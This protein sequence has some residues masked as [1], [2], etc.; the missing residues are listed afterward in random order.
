MIPKVDVTIANGNIGGSQNTSD[1]VC[2]YV[3]T[4]AGTGTIALLQPVKVVSLADAE[5]Q[6]LTVIAEPEAQQF[7]SDFYDDAPMGSVLYL[8]LAPNTASLVN[9]CDKTNASG[10][11]KLIDFA[12][13]NAG[14][15]IRVLGISRTPAGG[16]V[17]A[18]DEF[19][20]S[21]AILAGTN[22]KALVTNYFSLH[23]PFRII[24]A[25]RVADASSSMV[26]MPN[27]AN[28]NAIAYGIGNKTG[29]A[30]VSM[31]SIMAKVAFTA[32]QVNIGR[33][34]D[35]PLSINS[36]FIGALPTTPPVD[37][38]AWYQQL[39]T[40]IDGGYITATTYAGKAGYYISD[41]P[42]AT[43]NTDDYQSLANCRVIDKASILAYQAF[44]NYVNDEVDLIAGGKLD[45]ADIADIQSQ[46][47]NAMGQGLLGNISGTPSCFIDPTQVFTIGTPFRAK[48]R[49]TPKGYLKEIEVDLGFSF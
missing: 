37:G 7:V 33:V 9:L 17:P 32:P 3:V 34:K 28:N 8:M 20:D 38:S 30:G 16:Y 26:Y 4:G 40:L 48:I 21:D 13:G 12:V 29:G 25:A 42:M 24:I 47:V 18:T 2:G 1:G 31:G 19:I 46:I 23:T 41:D 11:K 35:G 44:L 15:Q 45:P 6:G 5:A 27:T 49:C 10:A 36:W 39:N 14:G 22:A 43:A